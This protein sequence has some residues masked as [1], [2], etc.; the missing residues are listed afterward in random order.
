MELEKYPIEIEKEVL[1]ALNGY[2]DEND[3]SINQFIK[4]NLEAIGEY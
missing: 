3:I 2:C 4:A 1:R